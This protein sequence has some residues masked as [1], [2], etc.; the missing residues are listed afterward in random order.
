MNRAIFFFIA[1]ASA[2]AQD[3]TGRLQF[4]WD[5]L[6]AKASE[7]TDINL[8]GPTLQMASKFLSGNAEGSAKLKQLVDGLKGVYVKSFEFDQ[9][10][11]YSEADLNALRSQLRGPE[12]S[13]IL[14]T[15]EKHESSTIHLKTDGK[16]TRGLVI[17]AAEPRE[18]TVV[19]IIGVIDP[20][21]L[22]ELGGTMGIPKMMMGPKVKTAPSKK[23]D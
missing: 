1:I 12:W 3:S 21:M 16:Q 17:I 9:E 18:L 6:A 22:S 4:D 10:G 5:K 11:Q 13:K 19:E 7:K 14:D 8:E 2:A 23:D 15:K 20:S